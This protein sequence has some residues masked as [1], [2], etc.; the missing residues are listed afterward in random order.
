[1]K[2]LL[3]IILFTP[4]ICVFAQTT[5][6]DPQTAIKNS[7][8][9][10]I[11]LFDDLSKKRVELNI[12]L[13]KLEVRE[14]DKEME[15]F[16]FHETPT[17]NSLVAVDRQSFVGREGI[18]YFCLKRKGFGACEVEGNSPKTI[19]NGAISYSNNC[20]M[21]GHHPNDIKVTKLY[22]TTQTKLNIYQYYYYKGGITDYKIKLIF[23]Q[24]EKSLDTEAKVNEDPEAK[25]YLDAIV[26]LASKRNEMLNTD[27][28]ITVALKSLGVSIDLFKAELLASKP[29]QELLNRINKVLQ[30]Y[31]N[32]AE[33][34]PVT[35]SAK[36]VLNELN[37]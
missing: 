32:V 13:N 18:G 9:E 15:D 31:R 26:S 33:F 24:L 27:T 11:K 25:M 21:Y 19:D 6:A 17:L 20:K 12:D 35:V 30:S 37:K 34:S 23:R 29:S 1:M 10:M 5:M 36:D 16:K 4:N 14:W 8:N 28:K 2:R 22:Q 7:L 3:L